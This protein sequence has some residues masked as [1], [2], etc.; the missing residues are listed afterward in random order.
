MVYISGEEL[1]N[2]AQEVF[3]NKSILILALYLHSAWVS[4]PSIPH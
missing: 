4:K 2:S 1:E 3:T